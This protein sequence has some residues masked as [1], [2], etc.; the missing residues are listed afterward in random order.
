MPD[1]GAPGYPSGRQLRAYA[2]NVGRGN[3]S[4]AEAFT[5]P[6]NSTILRIGIEGKVASN[7]GTSGR[8]SL[9]SSGGSGKDFLADFNVKTNGVGVSFP[10]SG[11][12]GATG[13]PNPTTVTAIYAED[14]SASNTGGPWVVWMEII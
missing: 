2:S 3:T 14:G 4:S 10:S 6:A 9:G 1:F 7:A 12:F 5:I 11:N 8:V 13:D